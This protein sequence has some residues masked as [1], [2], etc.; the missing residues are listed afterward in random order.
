MALDR[1]SRVFASFTLFTSVFAML[2]ALPFNSASYA[3]VATW[4]RS[5][6]AAQSALASAMRRSSCVFQATPPAA[7]S[8]SAATVMAT[9]LPRCGFFFSAGSIGSSMVSSSMAFPFSVICFP[10]IGSQ[11]IPG[12]GTFR[13]R[14]RHFLDAHVMLGGPGLEP[15]SGRGAKAHAGLHPALRVVRFHGPPVFRFFGIHR[16]RYPVG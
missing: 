2:A 1:T 5:L 14:H 6:S 16:F 3:V 10:F 7:S 4:R 8:A 15:A 12:P 9:I 13:G 11:L